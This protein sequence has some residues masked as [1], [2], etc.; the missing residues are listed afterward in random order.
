MAGRKKNT[1]DP[2]TVSKI[3]SIGATTQEIAYILGVSK[4]TIDR[5]YQNEL[6]V[7]RAGMRVKLRRKM[8]EMAD[9]GCVPII[10][11]LS[12]QILGYS[13]KVTETFVTGMEREPDD[14]L[15]RQARS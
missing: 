3:A 11:F 2:E 14:K 13:D 1:V 4:T 5:H 6:Q 9:K 10:I 8:F 7:G 12:K 15:V